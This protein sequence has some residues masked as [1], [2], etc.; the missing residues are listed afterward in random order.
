MTQ[1]APQVFVLDDGAGTRLAVMDWGATWLSCQV[2]AGDGR[3]REVLLGHAEPADHRVEPGYLGGLI[4][5][6]ANRI[7][8]ARFTLGG[9]TV[10]LQPNEGPHHLHGGPVGFD[11]QRW[12]VLHASSTRL[13]LHLVSPDGDQGYPG[14]VQA[15]VS[16]SIDSPGC[17][18]IGFDATT[19]A[20]C[21]VS[22]T[23]HAYFNLD[24]D[25]A[26]HRIDAQQIAIAAAQVLAVD[27][28]LIP[29]G[30]FEPV[31]GSAFDLRHPSALG[32]R[33]FDHCFVLDADAAAGRGPAAQLRSGDGLLGLE[34]RTDCPGLQLYTGEHL[35]L[36]HDRHGRR[37]AA[38][39][40]L[41][42]EP[43][44]LPDSPNHPEWPQGSSV[45][46]PGQRLTRHMRLQFTALPPP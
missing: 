18:L 19:T 7:A 9:Q 34:L 40:G 17:V 30:A 45:L 43:Q 39:T 3:T 15:T 44:C 22:L 32:G 20:P 29:T 4:G 10:Q 46:L 8:H 33:A 37:Y 5:R 14:E 11:Q 6:F 24:G 23:S 27:S 12:A 31:Q 38:R 25:G 42:L 35:A 2:R 36:V 21:P 41:A 26:G 28:A 1:P 13:V 16:Y